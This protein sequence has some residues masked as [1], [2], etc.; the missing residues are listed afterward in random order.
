LSQYDGGGAP[1]VI[2]REDFE[3]YLG[4]QGSAFVYPRVRVVRVRVSAFTQVIALLFCR[5][6]DEKL[7]CA[8]SISFS[9]ARTQGVR[10]GSKQ[11]DVVDV[12]HVWSALLSEY[13]EQFDVSFLNMKNTFLVRFLVPHDLSVYHCGCVL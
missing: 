7:A 11:M 3:K 5:V 4:S 8:N 13:E 6:L 1:R 12:E 2:F 10:D 9:L